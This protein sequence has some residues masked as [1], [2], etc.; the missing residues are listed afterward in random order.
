MKNSNKGIFLVYHSLQ[1]KTFQIDYIMKTLTTSESYK[2]NFYSNIFLTSNEKF[3]VGYMN[4]GCVR[5]HESIHGSIRSL[6]LSCRIMVMVDTIIE[7]HIRYEEFTP[8]FYSFP[9]LIRK[10]SWIDNIVKHYTSN[11]EF[12]LWFR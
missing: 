6:W 11:E 12:Q 5:N 7:D 4:K 10:R 3:S 9:M 1:R 8:K 2:Q